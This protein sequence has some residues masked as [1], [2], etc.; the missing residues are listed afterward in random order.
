MPTNLINIGTVI[1]KWA[2]KST[3]LIV[4]RSSAGTAENIFHSRIYAWE[5]DIEEVEFEFVDFIF[6]LTNYALD[7]RL[8][9]ME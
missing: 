8:Q 2:R 1:L 3:S 6:D 7:I 5:V 9:V 4:Q